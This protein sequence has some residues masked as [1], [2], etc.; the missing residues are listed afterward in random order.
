[1]SSWPTLSVNVLHEVALDPRNVRLEIAADVP[2]ADIIAD[3][4]HNEKV[5][6]LVEGIAKVGYLTHELPIVVRRDAQLVVVEGN[7]RLL[8]PSPTGGGGRVRASRPPPVARRQRAGRSASL[9]G[10]FTDSKQWRRTVS[11][12]QLRQVPRRI[13][14]G[15]GQ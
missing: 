3:L 1:M 14:A 4:F 6:P 2:E 12:G 5:L 13:L 15:Q 11:Q 9:A 10:H 7:R 8:A